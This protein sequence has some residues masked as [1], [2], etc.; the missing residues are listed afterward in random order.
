MPTVTIPPAPEQEEKKEELTAKEQFEQIHALLFHKYMPSILVSNISFEH[1]TINPLAL[2]SIKHAE[3]I[4]ERFFDSPLVLDAK[5]SA[6]IEKE[7]CR[8]NGK[9][10]AAYQ[11]KACS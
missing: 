2:N 7:L 11:H 9:L 1:M 6:S 8:F 3:K 4:E 10:T 5:F